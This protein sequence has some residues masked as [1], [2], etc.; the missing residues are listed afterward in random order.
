MS[1]KPAMKTLEELALV[2]V[3]VVIVNLFYLLLK[4]IFPIAI[5]IAIMFIC[6]LIV[7][8]LIYRENKKQH[9]K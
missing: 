2:I 6:A 9:N 7:V 4:A 8:Y 1:K 5:A 3:V